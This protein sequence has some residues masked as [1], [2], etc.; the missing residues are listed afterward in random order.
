[1]SKNTPT[2]HRRIKG[3]G[4]LYFNEQKQVWV[5]QSNDYDPE[6]GKRIRRSATGKTKAEARSKLN[7]ALSG[8][9]QKS[10]PKPNVPAATYHKLYD[11]TMDY[12]NVFKKPTVTSKTFEWYRNLSCNGSAVY[13]NPCR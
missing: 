5:A 10:S 12:L 4:S 1:M 11:F 9:T 13:R 7:A 3:Y 8:K 2:N 6:T